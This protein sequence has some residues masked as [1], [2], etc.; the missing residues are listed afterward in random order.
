MLAWVPKGSSLRCG[1]TERGLGSSEEE[2]TLHTDTGRGW[3]TQAGLK[4]D[5]PTARS[6]WSSATARPEDPLSEP[7]EGARPCE[8]PDLSFCW[9]HKCPQQMPPP[10]EQVSVMFK[11]PVCGLCHGHHQG[12]WRGDSGPSA[13]CSPHGSEGGMTLKLSTVGSWPGPNQVLRL[14]TIPFQLQ[15][16]SVWGSGAASGRGHSTPTCAA[17][18][19]AGDP[20]QG[21]EAPWHC[22]S[23]PPGA[24][25]SSWRAAVSSGAPA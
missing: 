16:G 5:T 12:H 10:R 17:P 4:S 23:S 7:V 25:A 22:P 21:A 13:A 11:A 19:Q 20:L 18:P 24:P 15:L 14:Q 2:G 6:T 1:H 8:H 3:V 9:H